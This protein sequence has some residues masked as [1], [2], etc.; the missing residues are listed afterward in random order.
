MRAYGLLSGEFL[1]WQLRDNLDLTTHRSLPHPEEGSVTTMV[2]T[3][4][5]GG[6]GGTLLPD[7][8]LPKDN[9]E[10]M[11]QEPYS[12]RTGESAAPRGGYGRGIGLQDRLL[13]K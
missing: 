3:D 8:D 10:Q 12:S 9:N 1:L 13:A 11:V 5:V 4:G 6:A 7:R 2:N